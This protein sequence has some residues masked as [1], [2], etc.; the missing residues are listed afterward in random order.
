MASMQDIRTPSQSPDISSKE[1][2]DIL[3][4]E[5]SKTT[6]EETKSSLSSIIDQIKQLKPSSNSKKTTPLQTYSLVMYAG[7][8]CCTPPIEEE[9]MN[10]WEVQENIT[11]EQFAEISKVNENDLIESSNIKSNERIIR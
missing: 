11:E 2:V 4:F 7:S 1:L 8:Y 9:I 10:E 5:S 3:S 6:C